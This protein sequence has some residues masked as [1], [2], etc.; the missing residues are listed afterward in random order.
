MRI[1]VESKPFSSIFIADPFPQ[2]HVK[3]KGQG[4]DLWPRAA[5]LWTLPTALSPPQ[6]PLRPQEPTGSPKCPS[7]CSLLHP[8]SPH[9][10][11]HLCIR[12]PTFW[13]ACGIQISE[14]W[15]CIFAVRW[16]SQFYFLTIM[17]I[18]ILLWL[19]NW[20]NQTQPQEEPLYSM[21]SLVKERSWQLSLSQGGWCLNFL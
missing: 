18:G 21:I 9:S 6:A 19:K 15:G 7:S 16:N 13:R 12:F 4:S 1:K 11:P 10:Y 20:I 17:W 2:T 5:G 8:A 3:M 14:P